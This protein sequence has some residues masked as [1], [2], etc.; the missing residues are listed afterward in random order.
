[1]NRTTSPTKA[2]RE[3]ELLDLNWVLREN[4]LALPSHKRPAYLESLIDRAIAGETRIR[5][6]LT[7]LY[8]LRTGKSGRR[9][10][11]RYPTIAHL[12]HKFTR[13]T[14][15]VHIRDAVRS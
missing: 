12:A 8:L 9:K 6:V 13:D 14:W 2:R 7:N 4:C 11:V 15:G 3:D 10:T 1:M 5:E